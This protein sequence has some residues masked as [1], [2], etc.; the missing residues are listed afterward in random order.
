MAVA[1][2]GALGTLPQSL[3]PSFEGRA[4]GI[5]RESGEGERESERQSGGE[6]ERHCR[7]G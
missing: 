5:N 6:G 2:S 7:E 3:A 1:A 4:G